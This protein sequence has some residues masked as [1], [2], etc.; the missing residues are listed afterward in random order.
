MR[1]RITLPSVR[2][3]PIANIRLRLTVR[4]EQR[5]GFHLSQS[6]RKLLVLMTERDLQMRG[7]LA[8]DLSLFNGYHPDMQVVHEE[9]ASVLERL[10]EEHGW[11]TSAIVGEDGADAAWLIAQHAIGLPDFQ[12]K[13]LRLLQEAA[14]SGA[15]P[16]WRAAMLLDRVCVFEGKLQVYGTQ[17][18][19]DEHGVMSPRPIADAESVDERRAAIGLPPLAE[20]TALQRQQ[21]EGQPKGGNHHERQRE[22][23]EWAKSVGWR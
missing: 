7:R 6:L 14:S 2:F 19:W 21:T 13:C 10:V 17:F 1:F 15:V 5:V 12:R 4:R 8:A 16:A 9:N 23:G 20:A 18:D 22:I 3:P 11:P